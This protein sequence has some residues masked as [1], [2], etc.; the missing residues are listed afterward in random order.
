MT[1]VNLTVGTI[2]KVAMHPDD[3][4]PMLYF[5]QLNMIAEH[6]RGIKYDHVS[7]QTVPLNT[8][9]PETRLQAAIKTLKAILYDQDPLKTAKPFLLQQK[10]PKKLS[11]RFLK[12]QP[13]WTERLLSEWK[14]LD[15][16]EAQSTFGDPCPLPSGAN[17]L[18]LLWT[19]VIKSDPQ[20]TKKS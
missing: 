15:Q 10:R 9:S 14:Q 12:E 6:L 2:E 18:S 1:S 5:D 4:I 20:K 3:G 7:S 16:Y 17:C 13:E 19:Y 11:R 8:P